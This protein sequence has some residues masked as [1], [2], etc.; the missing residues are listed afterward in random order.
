MLKTCD[1]IDISNTVIPIMLGGS[2]TASPLIVVMI[3][4]KQLTYL[5]IV[6]YGHA[7]TPHPIKAKFSSTKSRLLLSS[8]PTFEG[9]TIKNHLAYH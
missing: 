1:F 6:D 3:L 8:H 4:R 5:Y 7:A 9:S 2:T